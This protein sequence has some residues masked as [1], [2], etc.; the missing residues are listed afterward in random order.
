MTG[1]SYF[2]IGGQ[3]IELKADYDYATGKSTAQQR[4]I[5]RKMAKDVRQ[6]KKVPELV[7]SSKK[8]GMGTFETVGHYVGLGAGV[9]FGVATFPVTQADSPLIGPADFAWFAS[10][11]KF[12][13]KAQTAGR[14][15]GS[16]LD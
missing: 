15:V 6:I 5:Q 13:Q 16:W 4:N 9:A 2:E 12:T 14:A 10:T 1:A 8:S 3:V 11:I 7:S